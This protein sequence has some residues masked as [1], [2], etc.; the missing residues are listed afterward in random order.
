[1]ETR[2]DEGCENGRSCSD[3]DVVCSNERGAG[4]AFYFVEMATGEPAFFG[5]LAAAVWD[6]ENPYIAYWIEEPNVQAKITKK[7]SLIFNESDAEVFIDGGDTYLQ[8]A[9]CG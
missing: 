9:E 6:N 8:P 1:M 3:D 5:T 7:N 2:D 4:C